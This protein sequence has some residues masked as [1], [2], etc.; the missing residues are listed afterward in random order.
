MVRY[1]LEDESLVF[2]RER[3]KAYRALEETVDSLYGR[4]EV[5]E[6]GFRDAWLRRISGEGNPPAGGWYCPPPFGMAVLTGSRLSFDSLRNPEFWP[7]NDAVD[8]KEGS[9]YA[10]ASPVDPVSGWM[11]DLSVTLCFD[12]KGKL[13]GHIRNCHEAVMELFGRMEDAATAAELFRI[14]EEVFASRGLRSNVISR[15]DAMPTNLGHTFERLDGGLK[16]TAPDAAE[17]AELSGKRRFLNAAAGWRFEAGL[18]FTVEPQLVS[19]EDGSLPKVSQHY[20]IR[21]EEDGFTVC[22][23]LDALLSRFGLAWPSA[24]EGNKG[25]DPGAGSF[26]D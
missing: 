19:A 24:P 11:G 13:A 15:T 5:T 7:G 9:L 21:A 23:D 4:E 14:S 25:K 20:L 17:R 8:W 3:Q 16:G 22:N 10:Y 26:L 1:T 18:Q 6:S 12:G 2:N